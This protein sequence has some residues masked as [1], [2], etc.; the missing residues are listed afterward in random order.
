M[1]IKITQE[2]EIHEVLPAYLVNWIS[3]WMNT[4]DVG[5]DGPS[6]FKSKGLPEWAVR[7]LHPFLTNKLKDL[8]EK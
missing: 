5:L 6:A 3:E 1:K 4:H 7:S 8:T 2:K